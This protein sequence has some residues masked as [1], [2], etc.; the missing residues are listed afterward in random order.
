MTYLVGQ[1]FHGDAGELDSQLL[2]SVEAES[3]EEA[4]KLAGVLW[5]D[6]VSCLSRNWTFLGWGLATSPSG[7]TSHGQHPSA[8]H[9]RAEGRHFA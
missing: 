5:P 6:L 3:I 4:R 7:G 8:F 2:G 9:A 1:Q